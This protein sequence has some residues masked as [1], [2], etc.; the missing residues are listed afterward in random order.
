M[1]L[2]TTRGGG[3]LKSAGVRVPEQIL[4]SPAQITIGNQLKLQTRFGTWIFLV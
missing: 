3:G 1:P 2:G 4:H